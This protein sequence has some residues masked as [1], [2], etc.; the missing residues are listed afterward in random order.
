MQPRVGTALSSRVVRVDARSR[1]SDMR[2]DGG[3]QATHAVVFDTGQYLGTVPLPVVPEPARQRTFAELLPPRSPAAIPAEMPLEKATRLLADSAF[4]AMPVADEKGAHLGVLTRQSLLAALHEEY[5]ALARSEAR[6]RSAINSV[7]VLLFA[8][9]PN[10]TYTLS[11]GK[12]VQAFGARP[13]DA[14]GHSAFERYGGHPTI[15]DSIRRA[16][17]GEEFITVADLR[18]RTFECRCTPTS[19][20]DGQVTGMIGV[21]TDITERTQAERQARRLLDELA[22]M[23]RISTMGEMAS[24][25][26]HELN[27]PLAAIVAYVDACQELVESRRMDINQLAEVLRAVSSQA[28]RAGQIIHRLRQMVRRNQPVRAPMS[29]NDAVREVAVLMEA[30]A[31]QFNVTVRDELQ[32][33][34][35]QSEADYLQIQ[36]VL[37]HLMRNGF[38][39]MIDT[40]RDQR[41]LTVST[42]LADAGNIEVAI[43]D[44]GVGL[45]GDSAERLFEPFFTTRTNGVGLG[46]SISRTIVEAHGGRIWITPNQLRGVTARFTLP[47]SG[48]KVPNDVQTDGL[49]R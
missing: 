40:P 26:A 2:D 49:H 16:L 21:A 45:T 10:G 41:L 17:A 6:L 18:G 5:A 4:D 42:Q 24:G 30:E 27:Q 8:T 34:L 37:L 19:G 7:P 35:P 25:L 12:L 22:H 1:P 28:E 3:S 39:A 47:A 38:E 15:T 29:V 48:G 31:R 36:K 43:C 9:D 44:L 14:V 32:Q 11:E 20:A 33:N 13:G 23:G 46:L